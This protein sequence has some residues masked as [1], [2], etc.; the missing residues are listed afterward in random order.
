MTESQNSQPLPPPE[1][2]TA[3][4][5]LPTPHPEE[6]PS[7][8]GWRHRPQPTAQP[9]KTSLL[10]RVPWRW[11]LGSAAIGFAL[12]F[13]LFALPGI[14]SESR[15]MSAA[16]DVTVNLRTADSE[17]IDWVVRSND[18]FPGNRPRTALTVEDG[19]TVS[20][21]GVTFI[22]LQDANGEVDKNGGYA[23]FL[24]YFDDIPAGY[25]FYSFLIDGR[26]QAIYTEKMIRES[27]LFTLEL[28][29]R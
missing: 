8:S 14:I 27:G 29:K 16:I 17:T 2:Q 3:P 23:H 26:L 5:G 9:N 24:V 22:S 15:T 11:A 10:A 28:P 1:R 7:A 25:D 4:S 6:A 12:G 21:S 18:E 20:D 19:R 13:L